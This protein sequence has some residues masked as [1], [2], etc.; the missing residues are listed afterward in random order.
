MELVKGVAIT[1]FCDEKQL[2]VRQRLELFLHV[3]QAV[4][5][6]HQKGIIHRDIKPTNVLVTLHDGTPVPK[7]IDFGIVKAMGQQLTDKTLF[8]NF[9]Q[10]IGTPLYMSPEQAELSGLDVDTRSDI[11]SLGVLL[12]ELLTGTTPFDKE[13]LKTAGYDEMRRIIREEEPPK[14]ST[15]MSTLGQAATTFSTQR[16]S[17]P[18]RLSQLFRGEL[19]WIVMKALEKDRNRRYETANGLA[20]DIQRYLHDEP[21]QACPPSAGYK[22]KKFARRNKAALA[23]ATLITVALVI[24]VAV[25][26]VSNMRIAQ[27]KRE[28]DEALNRAT[29]SELQAVTQA[30]RATIVADLLQEMLA[31]ANPEAG[32]GAAFTV[33]ELLDMFSDRLEDQVRDQPEVEATVRSTIG[34]AYWRLGILHKAEQHLARTLDLRR[35]GPT[36]EPTLL[37]QALVDWAWVMVEQQK[38]A[39]AEKALQEALTLYRRSTGAL[40]QILE[41]LRVLQLAELLQG[42]DDEVDRIGQEALE[43]AKSLPEQQDPALAC[44][45]HNLAAL[46]SRQG[47]LGEAERLGRES[48]EMHRRTRAKDHPELAWGLLELG[49]TLARQ[50]KYADAE[51]QFKEALAVFRKHYPNNLHKGPQMVKDELVGVLRAQN[52]QSEADILQRESAQ[53]QREWAQRL[54]A[55]EERLPDDPDTLQ[56]LGGLLKELGR[57]DEAEKAWEKAAACYSK[58]IELDPKNAMAWGKRGWIYHSKLR[59]HDKALVD[60]CEAIKLD[61]KFVQALI[62]R[63]LAYIELHQYDKALDDLNKAIELDEKAG[64]HSF[65]G[66]AYG[67][68]W[69]NLGVAHY[70]AGHWK[71]AIGALEKSMELGNTDHSV[72]WFFLAMAHWQL[73]QKEKARKWFDQAVQWMDKNRPKNEELGRFRA[74]AEELMKKESGIRNQETEKKRMPD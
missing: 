24:A 33:R 62:D 37:A 69:T 5:H 66:W 35:N 53:L 27:E 46:R 3:C 72:D 6:A 71:E 20:R 23:M 31:S 8:T 67:G 63:G 45:L 9:A 13:R 26:A 41:A 11:Y 34:R 36:T 57:L 32:K 70:R 7:V 15:R 40:P 64:A 18:R 55:Q 22:L 59:Q 52:K 2:P 51:K 50:R 21:V 65:Q 25:L 30:H 38:Y 73:G 56:E 54:L 47:K 44:I 42:H 68:H 74:E 28:K 39:L 58:A 4:Q 16:K 17:D 19:D 10:L 14:P 43:L 1:E 49:R 48:V 60:Y 29:A 12:Y 61:P